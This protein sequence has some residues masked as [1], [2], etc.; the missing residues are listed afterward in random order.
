MKHKRLTPARLIAL[1]FFVMILLGT[2]LLMLPFAAKGEPAGALDALFT[3]ASASC[4]FGKPLIPPYWRSVSNP[5][6]R[7]VKILWV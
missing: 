1:G 5:S 2:G 3:S 4:V 7:P 6:F